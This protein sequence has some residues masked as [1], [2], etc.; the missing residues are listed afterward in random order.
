MRRILLWILIVSMFIATGCSYIE[1]TQGAGSAK[2][3]PENSIIG[4][5]VNNDNENPTQTPDN[6]P[7][8]DLPT[9]TQGLK[10]DPSQENKNPESNNSKEVNTIPSSSQQ[11][12]DSADAVSLLKIHVIDVGQGDSILIESENKHMLIDAGERNKGNDVIDYLESIGIKKIDFVIATH[13]HSDHIG[14]LADVIRHFDIGKVIMPD[15]VH[16]SKTFED[17]LDAISEK[18]L[19]ITKAKTGSEYSLGNAS[20]VILAPNGSYYSSLNNYSVVIRL[21]NGKN[22]FIFTGDAELLSEN[23]ILQ[24]GINLDADVLKLGHHG[25]S[26]SSGKQFLDA[27]TPD[28]ALIS[29]GEGNQ[30][31]HPDDDI[32]QALNNRNIKLFRTDKQGTIVLTSDGTTITVNKDPYY[33]NYIGTES[34]TNNVKSDKNLSATNTGKTNT[35]NPDTSKADTG[36]TD[37]GKIDTAKTGSSKTDTGKTNTGTTDSDKADTGKTESKKSNAANEENAKNII[38]HITKTGSKYHRAGCRHL[39]N[40]D[41]EVTLS[42]ALSKGLTPCKTCNPPAN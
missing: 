36:K 26:T 19:K 16:T 1:H 20:F 12:E 30:Y 33:I 17:M 5:N 11:A 25:S 39:S 32:I 23:E 35:K 8:Y 40:S 13:P 27:V 22:S 41:I 29:V 2:S 7:D 4:E 42:E 15:V 37:T 24:T 9:P 21:Q 28:I 6:K 31:G 38:V 14:G 34:K 3:Q 18:G 10:Q